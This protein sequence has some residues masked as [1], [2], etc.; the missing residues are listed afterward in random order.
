MKN[1]EIKNVIQ[2]IGSAQGPVVFYYPGQRPHAER[3]S[4][5]TRSPQGVFLPLLNLSTIE[6]F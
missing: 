1:R 6:R 4:L 5:S 2:T 3:L